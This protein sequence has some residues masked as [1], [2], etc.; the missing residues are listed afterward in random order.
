MTRECDLFWDMRKGIPF[1]DSS[2]DM[3]YSS[4]FLE[5]LTYDQSQDF[6]KESLRVLKIGGV[7]SISVPN[8]RV[9]IEAYLHG[10]LPENPYFGHSPAYNRTSKIDYI[11]YIAYMGDEHRY[12][13]DQENLLAVLKKAG[14][15]EPRARGFQ[16]GLDSS[17]RD[18]GSIYAEAVKT[19]TN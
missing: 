3:I 4:H 8:A 13:F 11:N 9:Y 2:V 14:F 18:Y 10:E 7:F 15:S 12:M 16:E 6:L 17:A 19:Q 5:H 1:P